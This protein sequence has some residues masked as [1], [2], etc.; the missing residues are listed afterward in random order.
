M[1]CV[2]EVTY[3]IIPQGV[4]NISLSTFWEKISMDLFPAH[5]DEHFKHSNIY[6]ECY[7]IKLH[8]LQVS[9]SADIAFV[10]LFHPGV[11]Q[12]YKPSG[13]LKHTLLSW[14]Q[15]VGLTKQILNIIHLSLK[16]GPYTT[17]SFWDKSLQQLQDVFVWVPWM[18]GNGPNSVYQSTHAPP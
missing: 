15:E 4:P 2:L 6:V 10:F 13:I 14:W 16:L 18:S 8:H 17:L 11:E 3:G 9:K 12:Q 7:L 5:W 1:S